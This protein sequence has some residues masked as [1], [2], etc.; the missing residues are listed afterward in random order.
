MGQGFNVLGSLPE[1]LRA[2]MTADL[3]RWAGVIRA[4]NIT[5]D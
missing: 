4:A 5:A 3:E 2:R 1:V